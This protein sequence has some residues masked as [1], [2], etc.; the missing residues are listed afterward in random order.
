MHEEEFYVSFHGDSGAGSGGGGR[1]LLLLVGELRWGLIGYR[2][3]LYGQVHALM[4]AWLCS[5][6]SY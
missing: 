6:W 2:S 1:S 3:V 4:G 5:S